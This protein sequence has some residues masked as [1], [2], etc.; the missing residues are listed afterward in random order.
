MR[1]RIVTLAVS[2]A[3]LALVLFGVPLAA[4][5]AG[6]YADDARAELEQGADTAALTVVPDLLKGTVPRTLPDLG[7]GT[8]VALYRTDGTRWTGTGP[9]TVAVSLA[10]DEVVEADTD[11]ELVLMAS[12]GD[13]ERVVGIVRVASSRG[14]IYRRAVV[15]WLIMGGLG[16]VA[17]AGVWLLAR[18]QATR[19][20][21]PLE[22]LSSAAYELGAGNFTVAT[23][24]SG[25]AEIDSVGASLDTTAARLSDLVARERAF[26]ADASHQLR[27]P[28]AGLRLELEAALDLPD[29]ELRPSI[30]AALESADQL[31]G[32]VADLLDLAR[33]V[34][35]RAG[36]EPVGGLLDRL[37]RDWTGLLAERG[38]ALRVTVP[39]T[40]GGRLVVAPVLRQIV[41]VLLD[42][43]LRHGDGT[44]T[45][46]VRDLGSAIG[47]DV[48]DEGPGV[49]ADPLARATMDTSGRGHGELR[50]LAAT[51]GARTVRTRHGIGLPL[52]RRLAEAE[53]GRL[54]LATPTPPTFTLVL[55]T[56]GETG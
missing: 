51:I 2:A 48:S 53:S 10:S 27:T 29:E 54:W 7:H 45:V 46:A 14:E 42:N 33:N 43:A 24:R 30:T 8:T 4:A 12:V 52:A 21:R 28:L 38:R 13:G 20:A 39:D 1:G 37:G 17:V 35:A 34:P 44:V 49:A 16:L 36:L 15:T 3:V 47:V 50:D 6:Y 56:H 55:P 40:V 11:S 25:I 5:V 19:L 26:T 23:A 9:A 18:R 41:A 31:E 32:T 22:D